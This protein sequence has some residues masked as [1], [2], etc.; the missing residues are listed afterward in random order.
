MWVLD[1]CYVGSVW[2][3]WVCVGVGGCGFCVG[4]GTVWVLGVCVGAGWGC[5]GVCGCCGWVC[6][7]YV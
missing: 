7:C 4:A 6:G 3:L 1:E 2:V 5:V